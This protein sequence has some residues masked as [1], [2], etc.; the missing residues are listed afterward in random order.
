MMPRFE[1]SLSSRIP[2]TLP[3]NNFLLKTHALFIILKMFRRLGN[4]ETASEGHPETLENIK[5]GHKNLD[6]RS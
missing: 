4:I 1:A 3:L 2:Q 6:Y 5:G